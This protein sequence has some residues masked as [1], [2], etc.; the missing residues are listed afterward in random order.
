MNPL[1][2]TN[3]QPRS[4]ADIGRI[5][6]EAALR[7]AEAAEEN[8]GF[9]LRNFLDAF[10]AAGQL[11]RGEMLREEPPRLRGVLQDRGVA[12]AY[13]A[14]VANHLSGLSGLRRPAWSQQA[15]RIPDRPW[16]ALNAPEARIWLLTQSPAAFRERDLFVS[17]DALTRA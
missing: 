3:R 4:V 10:Y 1:S 16:F 14:A 6:R 13:L 9:A 11:E 17:E 12:D 2:L 8:F 5:T 7:Q 15:E